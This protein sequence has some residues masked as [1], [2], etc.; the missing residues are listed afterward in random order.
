MLH[1]GVCDS[2]LQRVET[3][4]FWQR[5]AEMEALIDPGVKSAIEEHGIRLI[6]YG[7][8]N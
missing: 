4:L 1:P 3:R 5:D 2:E 7:G 8:L 6:T